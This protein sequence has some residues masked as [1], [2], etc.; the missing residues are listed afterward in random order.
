MSVSDC[1]SFFYWVFGSSLPSSAAAISALGFTLSPP[2]SSPVLLI[3]SIGSL[4]T[5]GGEVERT[6]FG[7]LPCYFE[8]GFL[9]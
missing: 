2:F 3:F 4:L 5:G 1:G 9:F 7:L 6:F 8:Y